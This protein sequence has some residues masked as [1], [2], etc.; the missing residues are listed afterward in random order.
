MISRANAQC[1]H[2]LSTDSFPSKRQVN[3]APTDEKQSRTSQQILLSLSQR[4]RG[5]TGVRCRCSQLVRRQSLILR[6][7][8]WIE[9]VCGWR[10]LVGK[11]TTAWRRRQP[12][13]SR[14]T[15]SR[16]VP[17]TGFPSGIRESVAFRISVRRANARLD[18]LCQSLGIIRT[19]P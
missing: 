12:T 13:N 15:N 11:P 4:F 17:L 9:E 5:G 18:I 7:P 19:D 2:K 8:G 16:D 14:E 6:P 10:G 3:R 1:L